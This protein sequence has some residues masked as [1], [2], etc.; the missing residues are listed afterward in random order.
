MFVITLVLTCLKIVLDFML[1]VG[2]ANPYV[3]GSNCG[4]N[5]VLPSSEKTYRGIYCIN[6]TNSGKQG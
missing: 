1:P 6:G 5:S 3:T 4:P 2:D